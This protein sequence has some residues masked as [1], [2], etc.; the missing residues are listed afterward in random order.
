MEG[1][2]ASMELADAGSV[3]ASNTVRA[4]VRV[5]MVVE[6]DPASLETDAKK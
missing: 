2:L 5:V 1:W 3:D 6:P 4:G